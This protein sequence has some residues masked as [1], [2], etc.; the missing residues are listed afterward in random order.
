[1][2]NNEASLEELVICRL[3]TSVDQPAFRAALAETDRW[4]AE[5]PGFLWRTPGVTAD[6]RLVDR[7]GWASLADAE[8]AGAKFMES[9]AGKAFGEF[10][11]PEGMVFLHYQALTRV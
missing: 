9:Q 7:C 3:R 4:L 10:L 11:D 1:M 5:Q 2:D 6:G 8:R